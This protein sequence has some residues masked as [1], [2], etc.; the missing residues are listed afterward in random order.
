MLTCVIVTFIIYCGN[1]YWS[2]LNRKT[3][4]YKRLSYRVP[5]APFWH[6]D[7]IITVRKQKLG[8]NIIRKQV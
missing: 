5:R 2:T 3:G 8:M 4:K 7:E 1:N 6:D